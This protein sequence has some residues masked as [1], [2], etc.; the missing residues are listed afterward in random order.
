MKCDVIRWSD[1]RTKAHLR[2]LLIVMLCLVDRT[3]DPYLK[4]WDVQTS[5]FLHGLNQVCIYNPQETGFSLSWDLQDQDLMKWWQ[6]LKMPYLKKIYE[7]L[8]FL[9]QNTTQTRKTFNGIKIW[10]VK[11]FAFL[12][13]TVYCETGIKIK[14]INQWINE[15][16]NQWINES[17]NQSIMANLIM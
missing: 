11:N 15:L 10:Q 7:N 5:L 1:K 17:I 14:L 12:H 9:Y 16:M 3:V 8:C 6:A 13:S 4:S 2:F